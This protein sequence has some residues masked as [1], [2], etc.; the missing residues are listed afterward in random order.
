MT[1]RTVITAAGFVMMAASGAQAEDT[2][3]GLEGAGAVTIRVH[4]PLQPDVVRNFIREKAAI[5]NSLAG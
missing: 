5:C 3:K 4:C 2:F 1:K